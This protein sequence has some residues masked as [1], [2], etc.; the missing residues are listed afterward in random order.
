M[1]SATIEMRNRWLKKKRWTSTASASCSSLFFLPLLLLECFIYHG[2]E[3]V[4]SEKV[5]RKWNILLLLFF[6]LNRTA[7]LVSY[8]HN[9]IYIY[10]YFKCSS[11]RFIFF[12]S[13]FHLLLYGY[14]IDSNLLPIFVKALILSQQNSKLNVY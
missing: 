6:T 1:S 3:D 2:I 9:Y 8:T 4:V 12:S 5:S 13:S 10:I 11:S 7:N 14:K